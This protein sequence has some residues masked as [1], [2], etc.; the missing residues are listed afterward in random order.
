[1]NAGL[2]KSLR[3]YAKRNYRMDFNKNI[4][5]LCELQLRYRI[6]YALKIIFKRY[7]KVGDGKQK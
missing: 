2:A 5:V 1:M 4:S 3:K 7:K 6:K